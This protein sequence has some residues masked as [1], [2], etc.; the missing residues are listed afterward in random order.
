M[1]VQLTIRAKIDIED[2]HSFSVDRWGREQADRYRERLFSALTLLESQPFLGAR[3]PEMSPE[4]RVLR[5]QQ[6]NA[7]Y[8]VERDSI[9]VMRVIHV[10]RVLPTL[11]PQ[12]L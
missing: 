9:V 6:H 4:V 1:R 7:V 5:V 2:I 10:R 3:V 11:N 8:R 12:E